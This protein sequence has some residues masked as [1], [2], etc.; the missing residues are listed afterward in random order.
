VRTISI[1]RPTAP[2]S[3]PSW[4]FRAKTPPSIWSPWPRPCGPAVGSTKW[5]VRPIWPNWPPPRSRRPTPCTMPPSSGKRPSSESSSARR[6]ILFPVATKAGSKRIASSTSPSR[7]SLPSPTPVPPR[8][9]IRPRT[10]SPRFSSRS[11]N[12]WRTRNSSPACPRAT[13]SSTSTRPDSS[14]PISSSWPA[15]RPWARPPLP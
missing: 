1:L 8:A 9:P 15:G 7:P 6:W 10:L 3:R 5:A 12:A 13:T 14:L 4:N 11:K 2:S